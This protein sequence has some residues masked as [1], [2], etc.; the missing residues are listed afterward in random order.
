MIPS[1]ERLR[2]V[3]RRQSLHD[4]ADAQLLEKLLA[5][6]EQPKIAWVTAPTGKPHVGYLV[7]LAKL[8]D[9]LRAGLD[10]TV[11]C[12]DVYSFLVNYVHPM[13]V[14]AHRR[15]YYRLLVS[16]VLQSLGVQPGAVKFVSESSIAYS[17]EFVTDMQRL[18]ALMTQQDARNTCE[19][20]ANTAMLSPMLCCIHQ[21]LAEE[22]L[23]MDIQFGGED[24]AGL[25][26]HARQ[27]MPLLGYRQR[28]H[29]MNPMV[30]GLDGLK[31]S[32]SKPAAT[33]I[34]FLDDPPTVRRKVQHAA[35]PPRQMVEN[36]ILE[37]LKHVLVPVSELRLERARGQTGLNTEEGA[38]GGSGSCG[39]RPFV[40]DGAPDGAVFSVARAA[41]QPG[42]E[43]EHLHFA[44]YAE[45]ER[46][47]VSGAIEPAP[48]KAAVEAAF[49]DLLAPIRDVYAQS[50][51][52][53][54]VD[55]AAYPDQ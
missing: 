18:C 31:M 47:Y 23:A 52:W 53:Q 9:F 54:E 46:A 8:V 17:K 25:F 29:L 4:P 32:S 41:R 38:G 22:Y 24:Q 11:Y 21:S 40:A 27:F 15:E 6:K 51:E 44:S 37:L 2:L 35:C 10:V 26:A 42:M 3:T 55:R 1:E 12:V 14:V 20:V 34:E 16:A 5:E 48:L 36:G 43:E 13:H 33:K 50:K 28:L 19:E 49:N 7:P 39:G 45:L 30:A